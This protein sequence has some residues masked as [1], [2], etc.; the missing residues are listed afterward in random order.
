MAGLLT[1]TAAFHAV[2]RPV[3]P[4]AVVQ[5]P[6]A[7]VLLYEELQRLARATV[8]SSYASDIASDAF[9]RLLQGGE[10]SFREPP[11]D[12][13]VRSYLFRMIVRAEIDRSRRERRESIM[14]DVLQ[15][16]PDP[17]PTI[18]EVLHHSQLTAELDASRNYLYSV[19]VSSIAESIRE[20]HREG[21]VKSID[22]LRAIAE[23]RTTVDD[24]TRSEF[25]EINKTTKNRLYQQHSR[26]RRYLMDWLEDDLP[27][28]GLPESRSRA[29]RILIAGLRAR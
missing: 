16:A 1:L 11:D 6:E 17:G 29:I 27:R 2:C 23:E 28:L 15:N 5:D 20:P 4:P 19:V 21:F 25:G 12:S 26:A 22:Q 3:S 9:Q 10:R 18:D 13:R 24:I 7:C 8:R 14:D